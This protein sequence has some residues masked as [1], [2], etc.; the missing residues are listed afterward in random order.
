MK[1]R[2]IINP[3]TVSTDRRNSERRN[4]VDKRRRG[5]DRRQKLRRSTD[6]Q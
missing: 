4:N 3:F 6:K 5:N 2:I 1:K